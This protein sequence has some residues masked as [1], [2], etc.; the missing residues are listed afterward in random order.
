[1]VQQYSIPV[2]CGVIIVCFSL[3]LP[4][5]SLPA[6]LF[7]FLSVQLSKSLVYFIPAR[8]AWASTGSGVRSRGQ[9]VMICK[10]SKSAL[11]D[12]DES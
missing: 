1:M 3:E 11:I 12:H 9:G 8:M 7:L 5:A 4:A 10:I 6:T 2:F